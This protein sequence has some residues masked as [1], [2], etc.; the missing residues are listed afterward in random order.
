MDN[1]YI[2]FLNKL[3]I[4]LMTGETPVL[5][6]EKGSPRPDKSGRTITKMDSHFHGN[7]REDK[8]LITP[9]LILPHQGGGNVRK[10]KFRIFFNLDLFLFLRFLVFFC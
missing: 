6:C 5:Y 10:E 7:D 4:F 1:N 9:T 3:Q 2:M 8:K